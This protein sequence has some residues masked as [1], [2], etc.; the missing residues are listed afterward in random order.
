VC[1]ADPVA[2]A[3]HH[4]LWIAGRMPPFANF[5]WSYVLH[6]GWC[7]RRQQRVAQVL[8]A[9]VDGT[10]SFDER[11]RRGIA[12]NTKAN[13]SCSSSMSIWLFSLIDSLTS[14]S[15]SSFVTAYKQLWPRLPIK[16]GF[17]WF[18]L[19]SCVGL[20]KSLHLSLHI[21]LECFAVLDFDLQDVAQQLDYV[22][23]KLSTI[24]RLEN[25]GWT[26]LIEQVN[27]SCGY[28]V[29][30]LAFEW[31]SLYFA[32]SFRLTRSI[33]IRSNWECEI[34]GWTTGGC[35]IGCHF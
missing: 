31:L 7:W 3:L 14:I 22:R 19:D 27:K 11:G 20:V 10:V 21:G 4:P 23:N 2:Q 6:F 28:F 5:A 1:C 15:A 30:L 16:K 12:V 24:I 13:F 18:H 8:L 17:K 26:I 34:I 33:M 9:V 35:L 29:C 32:Y 25:F